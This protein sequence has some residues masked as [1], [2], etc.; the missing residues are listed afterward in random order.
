[1]R[2]H[3]LPSWVFSSD[4]C[5]PEGRCL[6]MIKK[7]KNFLLM[8]VA[9]A[10]LFMYEAGASF[11]DASI[12]QTVS[13]LT[14]SPLDMASGSVGT[15]LAGLMDG[16]RMVGLTLCGLSFFAGWVM[17]ANDVNA[18]FRFEAVLKRAVHFGIASCFV[19]GCPE[20]MTKVN[21]TGCSLANAAAD[22][23]GAG[24][25]SYYIGAAVNGDVLERDY[26]AALDSLRGYMY[27]GSGDAV[28]ILEEFGG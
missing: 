12:F 21:E 16:F 11:Y 25:V 27:T 24:S 7:I 28:Q 22:V 20:I 1:M 8:M 3:L 4:G 6:Q 10:I 13:I 9:D 17:E 14:K 2:L 18:D 5:G 26:S 23:A 19:S 15:L